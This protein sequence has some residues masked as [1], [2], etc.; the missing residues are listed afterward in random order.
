MCLVSTFCGPCVTIKIRMLTVEK[1][2]ID[3]PQSHNVLYGLCCGACSSCQ[4]HRELTMRNAWP[5][6]TLF[7]KQPGDYSQMR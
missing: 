3:E 2:G 4:V 7:H 5:G 1:Y 6:G